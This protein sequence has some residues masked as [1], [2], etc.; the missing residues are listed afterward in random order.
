MIQ[1]WSDA[2]KLYMMGSVVFEWA[3]TWNVF[4]FW[5]LAIKA[6]AYLMKPILI[7]SSPYHFFFL[8]SNVHLKIT[9]TKMP[10]NRQPQSESLRWHSLKPSLINVMHKSIAFITYS[11]ARGFNRVD[12]Q[13]TFMLRCCFHQFYLISRQKSTKP[14]KPFPS[15]T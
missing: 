8:V 14:V 6:G 3:E 10:W 2:D 7:S 1:A 13:C 12:A 15:H 4:R 11:V 9:S 5:T